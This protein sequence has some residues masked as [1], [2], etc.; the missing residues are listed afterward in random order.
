MPLVVPFAPTFLC[1]HSYYCDT[2]HAQ[3]AANALSMA[4]RRPILWKTL[5][6]HNSRTNRD[7]I[8]KLGE[9]VDHVTRHVGQMTKVKMAKVR[10]KVTISRNVS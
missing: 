5:S 4:G 3:A 1:R 10:V 8:V 6:T 9:E 7:K 2:A